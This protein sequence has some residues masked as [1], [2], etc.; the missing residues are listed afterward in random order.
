MTLLYI[1]NWHNLNL[2]RKNIFFS[3]LLIFNIQPQQNYMK[4]D[5]MEYNTILLLL[6]FLKLTLL[7]IHIM[8]KCM[9]VETER[10]Q[11]QILSCLRLSLTERTQYILSKSKV[12][13]ICWFAGHKESFPL[14]QGSLCHKRKTLHPGQREATSFL[15]RLCW[16]L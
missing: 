10:K 4:R 16:K 5:M 11:N 8:S 12:E 1:D 13:R 3:S 14:F 2:R 9:Y 15:L 7:P 6:F